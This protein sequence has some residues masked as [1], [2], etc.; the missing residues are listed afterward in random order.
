MNSITRN[1]MHDIFVVNTVSC[2]PPW[3]LSSI[4]DELP[5]NRRNTGFLGDKNFVNFPACFFEVRLIY[6][7][8]GCSGDSP[9]ELTRDSS[10]GR[11]SGS[12]EGSDAPS[13]SFNRC[14]MNFQA[15]QPFWRTE[16]V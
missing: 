14:M 8:F 15:K 11:L 9:S 4:Q 6:P 13:P 1:M 5:Q 3:F 7:T 10:S 12:G 2:I 16:A